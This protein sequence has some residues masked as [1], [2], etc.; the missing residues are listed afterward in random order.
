MYIYPT[1]NPDAPLTIAQT[2]KAI[3]TF[4]VLLTKH[5]SSRKSAKKEKDGKKDRPNL[6]GQSIQYSENNPK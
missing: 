6:E 3:K 1:Q 2:R 5:P 4:F